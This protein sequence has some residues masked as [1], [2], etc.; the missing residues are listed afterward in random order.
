MDEKELDQKIEALAN[1]SDKARETMAFLAKAVE[2]LGLR[3]VEAKKKIIEMAGGVEKFNVAMKRS[4][5]DI[6]KSMDDLKKS[7]N[8]GEV[9]AEELSDQLNT[10][11][12]EVNKTSLIST[13]GYTP[14]L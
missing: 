11:R 4:A 3:G 12:N 13:G 14:S 8:K 2:A 6:K 7:I 5:A 9:S 10:L 1:A